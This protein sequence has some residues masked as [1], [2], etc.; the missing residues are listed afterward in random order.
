M[1]FF[2]ILSDFLL[3]ITVGTVLQLSEVGVRDSERHSYWSFEVIFCITDHPFAF[4]GVTPVF[5]GG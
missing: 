5:L 4:E 2:A 3:L 1:N